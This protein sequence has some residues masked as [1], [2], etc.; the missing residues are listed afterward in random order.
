VKYGAHIEGT[1]YAEF[2]EESILG[3]EGWGWG[4]GEHYVMSFNDLYS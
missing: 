1:V 2:A 3:Q 4:S